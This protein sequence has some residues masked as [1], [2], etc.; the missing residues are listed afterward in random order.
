MTPQQHINDR[1]QNFIDK[2]NKIIDDNK[3]IIN[4]L[5]LFCVILQIIYLKNKFKKYHIRA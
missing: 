4:Q 3:H 5:K 1:I 2:S